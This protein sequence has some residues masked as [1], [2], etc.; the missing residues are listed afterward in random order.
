MHQWNNHVS[1]IH[2]GTGV[3]VYIVGSGINYDH[4]VFNGRAS[5]GGFDIYGDDGRDC[6]GHGS[7]VAALAV[8]NPTGVAHGAKVYR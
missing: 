6:N 4:E 1:L 7:Y 2:A 3:D 5:F 8:G